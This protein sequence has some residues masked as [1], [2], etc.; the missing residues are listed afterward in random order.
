MSM[1]AL[2]PFATS[3]GMMLMHRWPAA[4]L[5]TILPTTVS[6]TYCSCIVVAIVRVSW[7]LSGAEA[8]SGSEFGAWYGPV[9]LENVTCSGSESYPPDCGANDGMLSEE[10][11]DPYNTAGVLCVQG[12]GL[13]CG[14]NTDQK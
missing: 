11:Y 2:V 5:V 8:R 9:S 7:C 12:E 10:C 1:G 3:A 14:R 4:T 6:L 13:C